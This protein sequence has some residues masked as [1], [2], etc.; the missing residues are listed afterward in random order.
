MCAR[1]TPTIAIDAMGGDIG[2]DTTLGAAALALKQNPNLTLILVGKHEEISA[3]RLFADLDQS[4]VNLHHA[5][6]IVGM[7]E[8]PSSVL[9]HKNDSSMWRAIELVKEGKADAVVSAGNTGALMATSRYILKMLPGIARPAIC[10]TVPSKTGHVHW[11]DLGANIDSKPTQLLQFAIMGSEVSK[12]VDGNPNPQVGLLNVGE[13]EIK[14]SELIKETSKLLE[15][16]ALNYIGFVEGND[17]FLRQNLDVVVC[18]GFVGNIALKSIEGIAK[19]IQFRTEHEFKRNLLTKLIALLA[20]PILKRLKNRIDPRRYNGA[21]LLGLQGIVI[22]SHGN[23]DPVAFANA[24]KI[25]HL[26]SKNGVLTHIRH[27]LESIQHEEAQ[28]ENPHHDL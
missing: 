22:K 8:P 18:D 4:R 3:H 28:K 14:G 11:L 21:S 7:D 16:S 19:F 24:I 25:A 26:E 5:S 10:A 1:T 17:I 15:Q 20:Y 23:A 13:E 6:Q 27:A 2:L 9:R 12:A